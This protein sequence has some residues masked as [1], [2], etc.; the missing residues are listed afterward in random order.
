M[1]IMEAYV[2]AL[3]V[4][5]IVLAIIDFFARD[6]EPGFFS[7]LIGA[8]VGGGLFYKLFSSNSSNYGRENNVD[9]DAA[10]SSIEQAS[11]S[12][13]D[14]RD[15]AR[16]TSMSQRPESETPESSELYKAVVSMEEPVSAF[17]LMAES[18]D[19]DLQKI[20]DKSKEFLRLKEQEKEKLDDLREALGPGKGVYYKLRQLQPGGED[21][22][23]GMEDDI[24]NSIVQSLERIDSKVE[25]IE[26]RQD[27]Y[28]NLLSSEETQLVR[29]MYRN[30][31][32]LEDIQAC[33]DAISDF[34]EAEK[35]IS[36]IVSKA[37]RHHQLQLAD[38]EVQ[39]IESSIEQIMRMEEDMIEQLVELQQIEQ[40]TER[41]TQQEL[42]ELSSVLDQSESIEELTRKASNLT[43]EQRQKTI[44]V[45]ERLKQVL[46]KLGADFQAEEQEEQEIEQEASEA[47]HQVSE[48]VDGEEQDLN[49]AEQK[50][51]ENLADADGSVTYQTSGENIEST[52]DALEQISRQW[53]GVK[54]KIMTEGYETKPG[55]WEYTASNGKNYA[56]AQEGSDKWGG[57]NWFDVN[58]GYLD[59]KL[60]EKIHYC[61][62]RPEI[63]ARMVLEIE[64]CLEELDISD[65]EFKFDV[66]SPF[67]PQGY[68]LVT[69]IV[70]VYVGSYQSDGLVQKLANARKEE[71][72][73][74]SEPYK[75]KYRDDDK[76]FWDDEEERNFVLKEGNSSL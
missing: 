17:K 46:N 7:G 59:S 35:G 14:I 32:A 2:A 16:G 19:K 54:Q 62:G 9:V 8:L 66:D 13:A 57:A 12:V 63:V 61:S 68:D 72:L 51:R 40:Q 10:E 76:Y 69:N 67:N 20:I 52:Y 64:E 65:Y 33:I 23:A 73:P 28:E 70:I 55:L 47:E 58:E 3:I 29:D 37:Q 39:K 41:V 53:R 25:E 11:R 74:P 1:Q 42:N 38:R 5:L 50:N 21:V 18:S 71:G 36:G 26:N 24:A 75:N 45:I 30:K 43:D 44:T 22:V 60:I 56:Y 15:R 31:R 27:Q 34:A 4:F 49:V 6:G 48:E